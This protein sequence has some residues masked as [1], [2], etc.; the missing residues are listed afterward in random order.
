MA[1]KIF[2]LL[3]AL[4]AS[5]TSNE[6]AKY[7]EFLKEENQ[8]LRARIL[9]QIQLSPVNGRGSSNSGRHSKNYSQSF[10]RQLFTAGAERKDAARSGRLRKRANASRAKCVNLW[11]KWPRR[12]GLATQICVHNAF[13]DVDLNLEELA[14]KRSWVW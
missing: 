10:R 2:H 9:G 8:I 4:I 11:W 14:L 12:R 3:L 1:A 5:A 6:L 13:F 7:I